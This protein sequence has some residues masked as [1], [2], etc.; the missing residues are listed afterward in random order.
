MGRQGRWASRSH[1]QTKQLLVRGGAG[2]AHECRLHPP[3]RLGLRFTKECLEHARLPGMCRGVPAEAPRA[4]RGRLGSEPRPLAAP[5]PCGAAPV[6]RT[7]AAPQ[8]Q[9]ASSRRAPERRRLRTRLA[10]FIG[11]RNSR[12]YFLGSQSLGR[13]CR[14]RTIR[15]PQQR[16]TRAV[17]P[18]RSFGGDGGCGVVVTRDPWYLL[19]GTNWFPSRRIGIRWPNYR[20]AGAS[21]SLSQPVG[22]PVQPGI[23]IEPLIGP[24]IPACLS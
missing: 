11:A 20:F 16:L 13:C 3:G 14:S 10:D 8:P 22:S 5:R 4:I 15:K 24:G 1:R 6:R 19:P 12:S 17:P 7:P 9:P 18:L 23:V 2:R 21:L